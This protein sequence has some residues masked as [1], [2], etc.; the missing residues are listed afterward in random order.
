MPFKI[1]KTPAISTESP[2]AL[3]RDL[4]TRAIPGLLSHQADVLREYVDNYIASSDIAFELPTGSG[5]T[6]VGLLL[7]EW[8]RRKYGERVLYLCPTNQLVN[9]V[10]AQSIEKYGI[11]VN[12]FTGSK[13]D[14][15]PDAK[16]EYL[17][18]ET[19]AVTSY[20][21][22]F[23]ISPFFS[24]PNCIIL[25]DAHSSESY[26]AS[27][28]SL[29]IER[30]N[31][32]HENL[33]NSLLGVLKQ[34]ILSTDYQKIV[35]QSHDNAWDY[36]WVD[37]IPTPDIVPLIPNIVE[38]I[39][40]YVKDSNLRYPW[41]QIRDHLFACHFYI[42]TSEILI[43]PL[44]PPTNN[45]QPF[46]AAKQRIYMSA[47]LGEGGELERIT[48][49]DNIQRLKIKKGWDKQGIGRRLF[50]LPGRSLDDNE[51]ADFVLEM[52][53]KTSRALVI[54]PDNRTAD[55]THKLIAEN[56]KFPTF[57][58][59]EIEL[60]KKSFVNTE[61]AVAIVAN[62]YDGIDFIDDECRLLIIR[63]LP[64]ATNLQERFIITKMGAGTILTDRILTRI[65][66]AF[67]RCTRSATDYS[68]IVIWDEELHNYLLARDR[69]SFLHPELQAEIE[70]GIEQSKGVDANIFLEHL[71]IFLEH[72]LEW[73][74]VDNFIASQRDLLSQHVLPGTKDLKNSIAYEIEYQYALWDGD[75]I[76]AL[77]SCKKVL[78][79]INDT[80]L[81]GY[82]AL[83]NYLAGSAQWL[84]CQNSMS[85]N[86]TLAKEYFDRAN[87][88][89]QTVT[90][91]VR[92]SR[93]KDIS[94]S[95]F[96]NNP[97]NILSLIERLEII[98]ENLGTIHDRKYTKEEKFILENI[99]V[100]DSQK[101]EEAHSRLGTML[102]YDAGNIETSGA[103]DPWWIVNDQQC[104]IF[105]DHSDALLDS[106]LHISK[107]RQVATHPNWVK[108]NLKISEAAAIISVLI[109]P[110]TEIDAD[111][112]PHL[113]N[114]Y[115]WNIEEFRK[116]ANN[117]L[118]VVRELRSSFPSSGDL[119]WR[120]EAIEKYRLNKIDP[121]GIRS[122]L[123]PA[124]ELKVR[125]SKKIAD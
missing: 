31:N 122:L 76:K 28:W 98:L 26:I 89:A 66:Q 10:V 41:M 38:V 12:G 103:P 51:S 2:E 60:S 20:S 94:T 125:D 78:A 67:G 11:N 112:L 29:K 18:A 115:V 45:H 49:R 15:S 116:W 34:V 27:H 23:N 106:S 30:Y 113:R 33:Y 117:A 8:R 19:I 9:Q 85:T 61:K 101:F 121:D 73:A 119:M 97:T 118:Q 79:E 3:F 54:T 64:R 87:K 104:F 100:S 58:A 114:V 1:P 74:E 37:K 42:G 24:E 25:D 110:V 108:E 17:N 90:W 120:A 102:G 124:S 55:D 46:K 48:G 32:E 71:D 93:S 86:Y 50:F 81:R 16:S 7:G 80:E 62:R 47:T 96:D 40:E 69:R 95:N 57:S 75:F 123:K 77:D 65:Q 70:F 44:L 56:L 21:A 59:Q 68:A 105:E 35:E 82:R 63:G 92:L 43:R 14:Y 4:R 84:S 5:K 83:W 72:G 53:K 88:A 36:F 91:L 13:K 6:L 99:S 52:I 109:T 39:D 111:C 22:L 107:A